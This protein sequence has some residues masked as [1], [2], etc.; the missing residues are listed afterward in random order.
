MAEMKHARTKAAENT[1]NTYISETAA[2]GSD[3]SAKDRV[4]ERR[5]RNKAN[6]KKPKKS[7]AFRIFLLIWILILVG[8]G[9]YATNYVKKTLIE[10]QS[11]TPSQM[12]EDTLAG[13]KDDQIKELFTFTTKID[14][15]DQVKNIRD[16]LA[17]KDY[18][19]KQISGKDSYGIFKGEKKL[20]TINLNKIKSVSKIG[21]FNYNLYEMTGIDPC[22]DKEL[23]HYEI[24]APSSCTVAVGDQV[25]QPDSEDFVDNFGDAANYVTLPSVRKYVLDHLTKEPDIKITQNGAPVAFEKSADI[26]ISGAG[27]EKFDS[28]AAAGCD[29]DLMGFA[30]TW[31]R[32]L[33]QDLKGSR[34]GFYTVASYLI[35]DSEQ[36]QK[37]WNWATQVDITFTSPHTLRNPAFTDQTI[38]NITK[39]G[40][41]FISADVHLVKH[42]HITRTNVDH[43]DV[44]DSTI[45]LINYNGEWKVVN[46]RGVAH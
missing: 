26:K 32:F 9:F 1:E 25:L 12:V 31:S 33:T 37:A 10:M 45:Y 3:I 22:E 30:E 4:M 40:E 44:M 14:E 23:Y 21:I 41:G 7:P 6:T 39:Y 34:Y 20:L 38:S 11:N 15:G 2:E 24:T 35:Q 8:A 5:A 43:D 18:E 29:F 27:N 17:S 36:Y 13:L 28:L 42:M 19:V 46:M 16:F